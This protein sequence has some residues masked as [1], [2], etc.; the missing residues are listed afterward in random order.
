VRVLHVVATARRRG[1]EM[2]AADLVRALGSDGVA[3]RVAVLR[4]EGADIAFDAPADALDSNG[5]RIPGLRV[6]VGT[7]RALRKLIGRWGPQVVQVHG[8]EPLKHALLA[9]R[10]SG[11]AVVYRRIGAAPQEI[12]RGP[13]RA[14]H[15][16]L[17]RR[18]TQIVAVA[19][20]LRSETVEVFGVPAVRVVTIPNGVDLA[21]ME[22]GRGSV[23]ILG[24]L[25]IPREARVIV[26][27]G[28]LTHEKNPLAHVEIGARVLRELP[29]AFHLIVGDGPMRR[30]MNTAIRRR[31]LE[32]RAMGLGVRSDVPDLLAASKAVL[33]ASRTE[34]MPG[35]V[36]EAG[37]V[38]VPSA[39]FAVAGVPE[40]VEDRVTG[41]LAAPGDIEELASCARALLEDRKQREALGA[42]ARR[43]YRSRFDIRAIAPRYLSLYEE[44]LA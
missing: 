7:I 19:E 32:G 41:L 39:A 27:L 22:P 2:F 42:N 36:I 10:G 12:T 21:R 30:E 17:M 18:A 16:S 34:G 4:G 37:M 26:S 29:D 43:A 28:A 1:A 40:V 15:A 13:R 11:A 31:A 9:A 33:L 35:C 3:Q 44:L 14:A 23:A 24:A 5:W 6:D 38:G 20:A 8:G 25:G